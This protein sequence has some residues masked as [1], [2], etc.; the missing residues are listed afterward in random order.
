MYVRLAFAVA[1]YLEPDTLIVDE[2]LA[3]GDALFQ[4]KCL[5]KMSEVSRTGRTVLFVTHNMDA[6]TTLCS[7]VFVLDHGSVYFS[8]T[9]QQA[10]EVYLRD[11]HTRSYSLEENSGRGGSGGIR[12]V[13]VY[14]EDGSGA[15]AQ[16]ITNQTPVTLRLR[17]AVEERYSGANNIDIAF[18][19]DAV[20]GGRLFTVISSWK[21]KSFKADKSTLDVACDFA[22][23]P[24]VPGRYLVSATV[25]LRGETLDSVQQCASF[26]VVEP[27][28][29]HFSQRQDDFGPLNLQCEFREVV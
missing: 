17:A 18:G 23:I 24:L 10:R 25:L 15:R 22:S 7:R 16:S 6:L 3:V 29:D 11:A 14:L 26:D 12:I 28:S 4:R 19:I 2:V 8:G 13:E 27:A 9:A 20:R 21:G 5:G 1:A